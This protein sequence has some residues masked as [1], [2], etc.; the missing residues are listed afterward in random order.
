MGDLMVISGL[1]NSERRGI[2]VKGQQLESRDWS[3]GWGMSR[4]A[5]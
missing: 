1:V 2:T 5:R 4:Q 3:W